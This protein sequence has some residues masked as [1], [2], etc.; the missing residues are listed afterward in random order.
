MTQVKTAEKMKHNTRWLTL[1][2][3]L[4]A[5]NV[6]L[7]SFGIPVP[8]G[9]FYLNDIIIVMAAMILDPPGAFLVG[10][11]GAFLGDFFFYPLPMFVSLVTHGLQ[12]FVISYIIM[13]APAGKKKT[14]AVFGIALGVIIMVTGYSLGRAYIYSTPAYA[15]LKLPYEI[16]QAMVGA[17]VGPFLCW[18]WHLDEAARKILND[19][20]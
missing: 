3:L 13:I 10:G 18:H 9:H 15:W 4:M 16:L 14:A 2:G 8:G 11:V 7:S 19:E 5:I 17:I 12:S 1:C 6:G 20:D